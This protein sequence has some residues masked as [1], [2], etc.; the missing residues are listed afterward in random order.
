MQ[1]NRCLVAVVI[2][3][4]ISGCHQQVLPPGKGTN[5]QAAPSK[6]ESAPGSDRIIAGLSKGMAYADLRKLALQS[7]WTPV[8]DAKCRSNVIG[9]DYTELCSA[10]PDLDDCR[11][12][13]DLP[14]LGSC[15]GDGYCGMSFKRGAATLDV[16]TYGMIEDRFVGGKTSR[17]EVM[18]WKIRSEKAR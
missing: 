9:A 10:H 13:D 18:G 1:L 5:A 7:G 8:V 2:V 11:V 15:S 14:E 16:T 12:C 3:G 17:L 4:I 6:Q